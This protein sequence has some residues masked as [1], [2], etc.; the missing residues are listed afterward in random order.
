MP[1]PRDF[2][3]LQLAPVALTIE[4]ELTRLGQSAGGALVEGILIATN[5]RLEDLSSRAGR[6][7]ILLAT[8]TQFVDLHGWEV[9]IED[10]GVRLTHRDHSLVLGLPDSVRR[11]LVDGPG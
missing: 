5:R 1:L 4:K 11:L 2:V 7:K 3:D 9:G 6:E 8:V 10:R